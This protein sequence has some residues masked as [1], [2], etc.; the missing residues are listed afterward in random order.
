[1][2]YSKTCEGGA[3]LYGDGNDL[4]LGTRAKL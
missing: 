2:M 1:M 3:W 4:S